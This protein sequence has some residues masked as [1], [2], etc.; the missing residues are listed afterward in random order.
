MTFGRIASTVLV[1]G[2]LASGGEPVKISDDPQAETFA[3][4]LAA[5]ICAQEAVPFAPT[6]DPGAAW[7]PEAGFGLFMHWGI[8]SVAGAQPSWAMIK[9][10]PYGYRADLYPPEK[11]WA[12]ADRFNPQHYDPDQWAAAA[13]AAGMTYAVL[14]TKHHDGYCLWPT[15][16]GHLNTGTYLDG[17]DLLRP[18]VEACRRHGLKVGF[19][20][21][22]RDWSYPGFPMHF[23]HALRGTPYDLPPLEENQRNFDRFY[24]YTVG[25][26]QEL[27]TT[28]GPIDVLW[29]DG[30][31]WPGIQDIHTAQTLA[32]VRSLQPHIVLN[33]RWG[34]VGD[35]QTPECHL[36]NG[37]PDGWWE[38]CT[39][40][41]G[42]WGYNPN[43][44]FRGNDWVLHQLAVARSW[45]GNLL[46][47]CG[48]DPDGEMP[49]G[50]YER[51]QEL[52][53]WMKQGK[54]SLQGADP[55]RE[56]PSFS[57]VPIT[58]NGTTWYCHL[59]PTDT[60]PLVLKAMPLPKRVTLL[61][62]GR[63]LVCQEVDGNL[64]VD[65]PAE[66]RTKLDDVVVIEWDREPDLG[67]IPV[68]AGQ[69]QPGLVC[70]V[71]TGKRFTKLAD[72]ADAKPV[73]TE[74]VK[75]ISLA[76]GAAE[77]Q[78]ALR[79]TGFFQA[80]VAGEYVFHL[81]SDDGASLAVAGQPLID[82]DGLHGPVTR[83]GRVALKAGLHELTL[84]YFQAGGDKVLAVEFEG[85]AFPRQPL[86]PENLWHTGE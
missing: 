29:W 47:N 53:G 2:A 4:E 24:A 31:G 35:F 72:F 51:C 60:T 63:E 46:L 84:L 79:F 57:P 21:S 17:R 28:Y 10:Y 82:V 49:P 25:Q 38:A 64:T 52:A 27:L 77:D 18:Y 71:F 80:P 12:L 41:N 42:H 73:R 69:V 11:Y 74:N 85:P 68:Q 22:P 34:G 70:E 7:F 55:L 1:V 48:P 66:V 5:R 62:D 9:D 36:P 44:R 81:T 43:G 75:E 14:T 83:T 86:P 67:M 19:Y 37:A 65:I 59:A 13:K 3:L 8:H 23:E 61:A 39:I 58:R 56:W 30:M 50:F 40:W 6:T 54:V 76:P 78:F 45:G 20:F 33:N 32:W 26:L 16:Y 15:K